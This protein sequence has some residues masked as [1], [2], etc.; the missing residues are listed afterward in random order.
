MAQLYC[1]VDLTSASAAD[2]TEALEEM[3]LDRIITSSQ[4][5]TIRSAI[6]PLLPCRVKIG[7]RTSRNIIYCEADGRFFRVGQRGQ[8]I[9][10]AWP[11]NMK[12]KRFW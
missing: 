2:L 7:Y 11:A 6:E 1:H 4:R 10:G 9:P 3:A 8:F 12:T 5:A